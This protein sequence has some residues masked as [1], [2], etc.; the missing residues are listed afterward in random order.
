M[1]VIAFGLM[2]VFVLVT[3]AIGY[4][5]VS[6]QPLFGRCPRCHKRNQLLSLWCP[7]C[8]ESSHPDN[9]CHACWTEEVKK[10]GRNYEQ[11]RQ[12]EAEGRL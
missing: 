5:M 6:D 2:A 3:L 1:R 8:Q 4:A 11:D 12:Q 9:L 7:I 10:I